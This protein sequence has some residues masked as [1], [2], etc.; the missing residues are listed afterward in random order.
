MANNEISGIVVTTALALWINT[1]KNRRYTYR[2]IFIPETIGSIV[3]LSQ[4]F[5]HLKENV[6]SGFVATCVGDNRAYSFLPS[7]LGNTLADRISVFALKRRG[8]NYKKFSFLERGSDERQFCSPLID[9]PVVSIMRSK[10]ATY[11]EY[12][13]SLDNL[14]LI[15]SRGLNGAYDIIKECLM[16]LE[17]NFH[18]KAVVYCEPQLGKR[19]LYNI[20]SNQDADL[21]INLLAYADGKTDLITISELIRADIFECFEV[22]EKLINHSL[23]EKVD[24]FEN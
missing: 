9:L 22:A 16:I 21:L 12:H 19:G 24:L 6:V 13:T 2:I 17:V 3:Y 1:L 11:P 14:D 20:T 7:R 5:K 18:Y 23:L 4:H 10:Y 15:S 8:I